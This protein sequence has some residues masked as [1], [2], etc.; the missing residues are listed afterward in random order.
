[1]TE[2]SV[3]LTYSEIAT[4]ICVGELC[5]HWSK[6]VIIGQQM[7]EFGLHQIVTNASKIQIKHDDQEKILYKISAIFSRPQLVAPI[8]KSK[9]PGRRRARRN[10]QQPR[11]QYFI[12]T[13][14]N[15]TFRHLDLAP[16]NRLLPQLA[17]RAGS[18]DSS[19]LGMPL[20]FYRERPPSVVWKHELLLHTVWHFSDDIDAKWDVRWVTAG[21]SVTDRNPFWNWCISPSLESWNYLL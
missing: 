15:S 1:M 3:M 12:T 20:S 16:A 4:H 5:C 7:T 14:P 10:A 8:S 13:C 17:Q 2:R 6:C 18:V 21:W 11:P 9:A 19:R